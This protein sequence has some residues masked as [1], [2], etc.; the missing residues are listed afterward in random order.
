M[1]HK[2]IVVSASFAIWI[3][4]WCDKYKLDL[5]STKAEIINNKITGKIDC[6]NCYG[7]EKVNRIKEIFNLDYAKKIYSYGDS[8][9][10]KEM[11]SI[12]NIKYMKWQL[13][14]Q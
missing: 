7:P 1:N 6:K 4:A 13:V 10:D 2:I 3:K 9:G 14:N 5:I 11:L 8:R 12:A